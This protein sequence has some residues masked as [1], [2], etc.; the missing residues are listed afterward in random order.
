MLKNDDDKKKIMVV[1]DE[2]D[3]ILSVKQIFEHEEEYEVIS[4]KNGKECLKM[5]KHK[6]IPDIILLDIMMPKMNGWDV[7]KRLKEKNEWK[8]IPVIIITALGSKERLAY[9]NLFPDDHIEK[10]YDVVDL[11][12]RVAQILNNN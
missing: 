2:S 3:Q 8:D 1:D 7:F 11:K 5:L 9:E 12:K 4:A 10:P 6:I